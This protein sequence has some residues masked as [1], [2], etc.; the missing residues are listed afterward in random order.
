MGYNWQQGDTEFFIDKKDFKTVTKLISDTL[1]IDESRHVG[2]ALFEVGWHAVIKDGNIVDLNMDGQ[3]LD[4]EPKVFNAIAPY[5]KA[6]SY[7]ELVGEDLF[8]F[9]F[10]FDG[11]KCIEQEPVKVEWVGGDGM[12]GAAGMKITCPNDASHDRFVTVVHVT[13][14][15]IVNSKGEFE[16]VFEGGGGEV[17]HGPHPDNMYTCATCGANCKTEEG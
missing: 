2:D 7:I 15:W 6:G 3:R 16:E 14:D 17:V 13:E 9:R 11:E 8:R 10:Y 4:E 5:V 1:G 12:V